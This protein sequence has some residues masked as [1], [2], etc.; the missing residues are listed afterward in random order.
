MALEAIDGIGAKIIS[1]FKQW[2]E[3]SLTSR[4]ALSED[5][6]PPQHTGCEIARRNK[7]AI[8]PFFDEFIRKP[9]KVLDI[10]DIANYLHPSK[11]EKLPIADQC[12]F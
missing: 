6:E 10:G 7:D 3:I 5:N 1:Q 11:S 12:P 8:E 4:N 9:T 2:T